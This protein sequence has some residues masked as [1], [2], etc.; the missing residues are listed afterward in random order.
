MTAY[1]TKVTWKKKGEQ[2]ERGRIANLCQDPLAAYSLENLTKP[3]LRNYRDRRLNLVSGSTINRELALI[4]S[5]LKWARAERDAPVDPHMID[6]LKQAENKARE[7]RLQPGEYERLMA[8]APAWLQTYVTLAV[9]T[10]MRRGELPIEVRGD[11]RGV[12]RLCAGRQGRLSC[13]I[14]DAPIGTHIGLYARDE[15]A[16]VSGRAALHEEATVCCCVTFKSSSISAVRAS[17]RFVIAR[18]CL[19]LIG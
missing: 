2:Q 4:S 15:R 7:R 19:K 8:A 17:S 14:C 3:V 16:Q 12:D 1:Q 9:E 5:V 10:C 6:G 11:S 13:P 18:T